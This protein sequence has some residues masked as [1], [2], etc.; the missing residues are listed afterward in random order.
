MMKT[1]L[2]LVINGEAREVVA[3]RMDETYTEKVYYT[4]EVVGQDANGEDIVKERKLAKPE[5]VEYPVY[6]IASGYDLTDAMWVAN[7][8]L[9][10][11]E[12]TD[13]DFDGIYEVD[14]DDDSVYADYAY[15]IRG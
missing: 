7:H 4:W 6:A 11:R 5:L 13:D 14:D 8:A 2:T 15:V 9:P 1:K 10:L 12:L 3:V